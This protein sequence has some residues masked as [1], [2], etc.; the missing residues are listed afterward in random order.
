MSTNIS[1]INKN[2]NPSTAAVANSFIKGNDTNFLQLAVVVDIILDD[3]HPFFGINSNNSNSKPPPTVKYQQ[4]PINYENKIPVPS[5][6][7]FSYIGRAKIRILSEEKQT[8]YEKLPWA[9]P[10]D[11]TITQFPLLNEQVLV[12]KIGEN[13]YYTKPF[14]R[15]NFL[16]T[17]GDFVTEKS[18]SD[19]GNSAIP[20]FKPKNR[21]SYVSHPL[22]LPLN[23]NGYFGNYFILNPY[24]RSVRQFEGDTIIESRFG[25]SIRFSAY[26]DNRL[27]DKG[28]GSS[29][30]LD[31][32][33]LKD[34]S[35]GGYGNPKLT[36]RNRQRNISQN[37]AQQLHPKLPP[38]PSITDKGKNYG[39]QI[40]ED[41]NNDG[42]TIQFTSG[43]TESSWK[44]TVYKSIFGVT[45]DKKPT[46][47]QVKFNPPN[48]TT[49]VFPSL[50]G[51]QIVINTDRLV[52]SSRFAET[53]HF[54][55][56]R[57][58]VATDSEYT[59][60]AN[61]QVVITTN[62]TATINAPQI[63]LGQYGETNEPALL[64]QTTVDWMYDLCN[65]LLDHVH[66]YHHVH[67][68]PHGHEDAGKID[69]ENTNDANPDQT[70][71]PV[72]QIKLKLLR[73]NLHKTLSRRVFVTGG[74][75]APGSNGVK[76]TGSGGECKDPV[77]INTVTGDGVVSGFKGRNR[78]EGPVQV[79]FEFE[80]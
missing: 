28:F 5:N 66:W 49:F 29:Y 34:S 30:T 56:K 21:K 47:D 7:D 68:H 73:D 19:D 4:I 16:G 42:S 9:I 41:I 25:Q 51:D 48:S 33:L 69:A 54:S 78:R 37:K 57:Y 24:I 14:N 26:D 17:N 43:Y 80:N 70:Q 67:P 55:K 40:D 76:P 1:T 58:A 63:F 72:Q 44:T 50:N 15:L 53:F 74:G 79:E 61:D 60:D 32:N 12:L 6:T 46:E 77:N 10:L 38:I 31:G 39:G 64:G 36:L 59:V 52:L 45:A 2:V 11:N 20:Y 27:I 8:A 71:I 75:Y 35:L 13:Y 18:S 23:Q 3:T 65:W 62:N 22:F